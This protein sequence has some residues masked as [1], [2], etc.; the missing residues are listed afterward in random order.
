MKIVVA[1]S[2]SE[3]A[4]ATL[5]SQSAWQVADLGRKPLTSGHALEEEI[6][7]ADAL[8]VRS[9][10]KVTARLLERAS[11]L[12]AIGRAGVGVDN[13]DLDA[14]TK[15][16]IVVMNTPG[17][18][19]VSVAEHTLALILA[20]ARRLPHAD[21][22]LAQPRLVHRRRRFASLFSG[23]LFDHL[24]GSPL[25]RGCY[26]S[27]PFVYP[28]RDST[29]DRCRKALTRVKIGGRSSGVVEIDTR[30]RFSDAMI[31]HHPV[32]FSSSHG[33]SPFSRV[34]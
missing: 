13:V 30:S 20:L 23:P 9:S 26:R 27:V 16:G 31:T 1:D 33:S 8:I 17:G 7:D 28:L 4:L 10:T 25:S 12:R 5:R 14:A 24:I 29:C 2:I 19:A 34:P 22:L 21:S 32:V 6:R 18:N 11:R 15:R 3:S